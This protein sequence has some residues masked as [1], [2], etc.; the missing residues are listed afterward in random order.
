VV[1]TP[2]RSRRRAV[3]FSAAELAAAAV[4]VPDRAPTRFD[5]QDRRRRRLRCPITRYPRAPASDAVG[6]FRRRQISAP[7]TICVVASAVRRARARS[8]A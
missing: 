2:R 4:Q 8:P 3:V 7:A 1:P 5:R 6:S